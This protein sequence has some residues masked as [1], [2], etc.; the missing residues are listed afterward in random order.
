M[1]HT[2]STQQT[3]TAGLLVGH[4]LQGNQ[5]AFEF[6]E[7]IARALDWL[8]CGVV[9]VD[10][11]VRPIFANRSAL[12]LMDTGRLP[13]SRKATLHRTDPI[14]GIRQAIAAFRGAYATVTCKAGDPPLICTVASLPRPSAHKRARA[15]LFVTAPE[16]RRTTRLAD[17][18]GFGLTRAEAAFAV[19]F[20]N[21][22]SLQTCADRLGISVTTA[23][24]HLQHIF[25]KTG[26]CRQAELMRLILTSTPALRDDGESWAG[27]A[28]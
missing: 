3:L 7:L 20:A 15:I 13:L 8:S 17:V 5:P 26:A 18:A 1:P 24:S 9:I 22:H 14:E 4:V 21:G 6:S 2:H 16:Q 19:E 12:A 28:E 10:E 27:A 11:D 23:K 25:E